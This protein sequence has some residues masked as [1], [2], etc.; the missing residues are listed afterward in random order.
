MTLQAARWQL[1][2]PQLLRLSDWIAV[3][4]A[5][6]L[7][8]ST[9]ATGILAVCWVLAAIPTFDRRAWQDVG[10]AAAV[11]LPIVIVAY[12]L[13]GT[14]WADIPW[15]ERLRGV[16]P[17]AKLLVIPLL[18]VHFRRTEAA[19]KVIMGLIASVCVLLAASW[20]SVLVPSVP[21]SRG[22]YGIPV[23]D[24]IIQSG[25]FSLCVVILLDRALTV[26]NSSWKVSLLLSALSALFFANIV[27]VATG[28]TTLV[29]MAVLLVLIGTRHCRRYAL[30]LFL[31]ALGLLAAISWASSSYLRYRASNVIEEVRNFRPNEVDTSSGARIEFWKQSL[32]LVRE[33]PVFGHGTGTTRTVMSRHAGVDPNASGSPSNPHNQI[34]AIAIPLGLVGVALLLGMWVSHLRLFLAPGH[35]AWFGMAVVVQNIVGGLFNSHLFDFSQGWLYVLGV[36]VAGGTLMR[37]RGAKP[38]AP[39]SAIARS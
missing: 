1:A 22:N 8:W 12:A 2:N 39:T 13:A 5:V 38:Q 27:F 29:S 6:S 15:P 19:D 10:T 37:E 14:L 18:F 30:L 21:W 33:D 32:D 34:F 24:Y 26:W 16:S 9:S 20:F 11:I 25:L 36:G 3:A 23:K 17:F 4:L 7:P 31:G 28:R 35:V